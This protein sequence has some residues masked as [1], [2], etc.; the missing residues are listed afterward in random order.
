MLKST[1]F[2]VILGVILIV[3]LV[4]LMLIERENPAAGSEWIRSIMGR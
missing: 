3:A 1:K 4:V 2:V